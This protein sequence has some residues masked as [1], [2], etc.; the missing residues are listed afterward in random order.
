MGTSKRKPGLSDKEIGRLTTVSTQ[1]RMGYVCFIA[2]AAGILLLVILFLL[3][4]PVINFDE[5]LFN[6][7]SIGLL[8]FIGTGLAYV[9]MFIVGFP[10]MIF[11][12]GRKVG[13]LANYL[14]FGFV[15]GLLNEVFFW[16]LSFE[17][18]SISVQCGLMVAAVSWGIMN[19]GNRWVDKRYW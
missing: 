9:Q 1:T 5:E 16:F 11:L 13:T 19:I 12:E 14:F 3:L 8:L 6:P 2:P 15:A 17:V 4:S 10:A 7:T 18:T